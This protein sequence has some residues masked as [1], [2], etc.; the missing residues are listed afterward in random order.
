MNMKRLI[1]SL[2]C[3]AAFS[4]IAMTGCKKDKK[5]TVDL[6]RI[7]E[8]WAFSHERDKAVMIFFKDGTAAFDGVMYKSYEI[9]D[10]F[11]R[12]T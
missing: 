3:I 6:D 1:L 11:I 9:T 5:D 8:R 7:S 2:L 4:M 12:F 10:S